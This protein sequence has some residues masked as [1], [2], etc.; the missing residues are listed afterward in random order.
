MTF[1]LI[2]RIYKYNGRKEIIWGQ[3]LFVRVYLRSILEDNEME[4]K[5]TT[6]NWWKFM[7]NAKKI[8]TLNLKNDNY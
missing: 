1:P 4:S 3:D 8:G 6:E 2:N 5:Y 7:W